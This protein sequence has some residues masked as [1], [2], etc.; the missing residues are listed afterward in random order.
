MGVKYFSEEADYKDCFIEV[1]DSWTVKEVKEMGEAE[2]EQ[3]FEI[4]RKKVEA[5]YLKDTTG[6]EFTNPKTFSVE[7]VENFDIAMA[8]FI[9]SAL[10]LHCRR[11]KGLGGMNVRTLS[12]G[13]DT[14]KTTKN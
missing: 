13:L 10:A 11:R 2:E 7:D 5:M 14:A 12:S 8:G 9:G 3:Y 4:F 1:A 6:K